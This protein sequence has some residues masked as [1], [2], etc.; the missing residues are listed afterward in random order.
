MWRHALERLIHE[1]GMDAEMLK[2]RAVEFGGKA[3]EKSNYQDR[4]SPVN[5]V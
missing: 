2:P 5:S 4:N 3:N 1:I